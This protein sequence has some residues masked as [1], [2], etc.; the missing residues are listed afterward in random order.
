MPESTKR[1]ARPTTRRLQ[2]MVRAYREAGAVMAA[3]ELELFTHLANGADTEAS[4]TQAMG[5]QPLHGERII[6][7]MLGLGL[8]ERDGEQLSLAADVDRFLVKDKPTYAG[9]WMLFTKPDWNSWGDLA[10]ILKEQAPPVLDNK[11]VADITIDEARRYH[12]GTYSIG[13]GAGRLFLKHVD[14][15]NAKLMIDIGGGSGAYCIEACKLYPD[16]KCIVLEMP[17]VAPVTQEFIDEN[18]LTDRIE[19]RVCDFNKD[20]FPENAD[21]AVMASNLPMYGREAIGAAVAKAYAAMAPGGSFHLIGEAL[22]ADRSG[23]ADPAMW[24]L[25]QAIN[26]TTGIAHSVAEVE[27]YLTATGFQGVE[28]VPFVEGILQRTSGTRG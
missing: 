27:G 10:G 17:A 25:A 11:T 18:G 6:I 22:D 8:L 7:A 12:R 1:E 24:G 3:V 2:Q 4:L 9:Q 14:L 21:I 13:R 26:N 23:P 20:P 16:L 5:L 15:S 28:T 19:A